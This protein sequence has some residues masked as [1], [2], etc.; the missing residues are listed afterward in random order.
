MKKLAVPLLSIIFL[1]SAFNDIYCADFVAGIIGRVG[2]SS[3]TTDRSKIFTSNF[4]DFDNSF[5][6][7]PGI[8]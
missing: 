4:R 8:F 7:Q 2:A 6:F 1:L 5:S 3:A